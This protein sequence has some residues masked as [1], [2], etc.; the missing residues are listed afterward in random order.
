M[1]HLPSS[2][3]VDSG[4]E[5]VRAR[6]LSDLHEG[7][8]QPGDRVPSVRRLADLTGMNRKTIHRAYTSL[9]LE[10]LLE[11][12]PGSGTYI[13]KSPGQ[14]AADFPVDELMLALSH[15]REEAMAL[16]VDPAAF[17]AFLC[18]GL[19]NGL[20]GTPVT[21][22]ESSDERGSVLC[23]ALGEQLQVEPRFLRIQDLEDDPQKAIRGTRVVVTTAEHKEPLTKVFGP[24]GISVF[25]VDRES[26]APRSTSGSAMET[27]QWNLLPESVENLKA[28]L[29]MDLALRQAATR[30]VC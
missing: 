20:Q 21:V 25:S 23:R 5:R 7:R 9:A 17:V 10:G 2:S 15:S 3:D 22:A 6:L 29:S 8:L 13:S 28:T 1:M 27:R 14:R 12:R 19:A 24:L 16:H 30:R 4:L 26:R 18:A 11:A